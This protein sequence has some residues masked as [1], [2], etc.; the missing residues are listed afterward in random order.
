[1]KQW[2]KTLLIKMIEAR[3]IA[4]NQ[5]I[6]MMQLHAMTDYELRDIGIG[7]ADI[8]RVVYEDAPKKEYISKEAKAQEYSKFGWQLHETNNA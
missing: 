4:V 6:A 7:R 5:R 8:R 2:F 1:M 3:Q